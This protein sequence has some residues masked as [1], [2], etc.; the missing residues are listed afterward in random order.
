MDGRSNRRFEAKQRYE[1][2]I[3]NHPTYGEYFVEQYNTAHE[4]LIV[5]KQTGGR[6]TTSIS[7]VKRYSVKDPLFPSILGVGVVGGLQVRSGGV[8]E[9][10]YLVWKSMLVRCYCQNYQQKFPS[11][12]GCYVS[13]EF[14]HYINFKEWYDKQANKSKGWELDKDILFKGNKIYSEN[15]CCFVPQEINSLVSSKKSSSGLLPIGVTYKKQLKK[16][17]ANILEWGIYNHIGYYDTPG[18]AF[19]AY[20]VRKEAHIKDVANKWRSS[21]DD[22]VYKALLSWE[23]SIND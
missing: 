4:V 17:G 21:L 12:I 2:L 8:Y 11:Y 18:D 7:N 16:Y 15:T 13:E 20:K 1:G 10:S 23:V 3:F 22:R 9:D 5:F 6:Y 19:Q 14:K